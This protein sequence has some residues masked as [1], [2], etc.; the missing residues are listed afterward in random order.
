[1]WTISF[2]FRCYLIAMLF[3]LVGLLGKRYVLLALTIA[4]GFGIGRYV[5]PADV[6]HPQHVLFGINALRVSDSMA[7][8]AAL[9]MVGSCYARFRDRISVGPVRTLAASAIFVGAVSNPVWLRPAVLVA[10]SYVV[11]AIATAPALWKW[12]KASRR[13]DLSYGIYLYGWP[14]Q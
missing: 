2:E 8:F 1:M 11:F 9:F 4:V 6:A 3:G 12:R 7:W 14:V 10:G 13:P 5:P